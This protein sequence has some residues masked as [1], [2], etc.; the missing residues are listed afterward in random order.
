LRSDVV[1]ENATLEEVRGLL[2]IA[3]DVS[4]VI[5]R[6]YGLAIEAKKSRKNTIKEL[7]EALVAGGSAWADNAAGE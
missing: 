3:E 1:H 2:P 5:F 6:W 4:R 7:D